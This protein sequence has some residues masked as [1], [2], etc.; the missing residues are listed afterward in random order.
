MQAAVRLISLNIW[1]GKV[2]EPLIAFFEDRKSE[3]D[4]FCLQEVF[5]TDTDIEWS[6]DARINVL[7]E[8]KKVLGDEFYTFY[9]PSAE[10]SDYQSR[11]TDY[12]IEYGLCTFIRKKRFEIKASGEKFV[13]LS[14]FRDDGATGLNNRNVQFFELEYGGQDFALFNFHGLWTGRRQGRH[15]RANRTITPD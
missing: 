11:V 1:G 14:K 10:N 3:V 8:I 15:G 4:V 12:H 6:A 9:H 2:F 7:N 5:H 13:F